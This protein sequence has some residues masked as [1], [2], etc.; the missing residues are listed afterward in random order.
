MITS[1]TYFLLGSLLGGLLVGTIFGFV[2]RFLVKSI[3]KE[4]LDAIHSVSKLAKESISQM[5]IF[6]IDRYKDSLPK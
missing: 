6:F 5:Y 3:E 1:M 4:A 2:T